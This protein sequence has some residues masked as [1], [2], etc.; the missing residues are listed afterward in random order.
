[1]VA[2]G[3]KARWSASFL[4]LLLSVFNV[5]SFL[6]RYVCTNLLTMSLW[7]SFRSLSTTFGQSTLLTQL[8]IS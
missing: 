2:V 4:V 6:L 8:V 5:G 1:M 3:F 7:T